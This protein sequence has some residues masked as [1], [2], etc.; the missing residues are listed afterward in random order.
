MPWDGSAYAGFS[1][2]EPWLPLNDDWPIRNVAAQERDP[3]SLLSLYR[4]LLALRR[5][6]DALSVGDFSLVESDEDVLAY[7]RQDGDER[8]L[9]ALNFCPD[10]RRLP[11]PADA[12][13]AELLASTRP[14]R[15]MDGLLADDE[16]LML[17]LT[18][19]R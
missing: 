11:L 5:S 15:L 18:S 16:G 10:G 4:A 7:Q 1:T 3:A 12:A 2:A 6:H 9:I 14:V 8:L 13:I 19:A 17:R